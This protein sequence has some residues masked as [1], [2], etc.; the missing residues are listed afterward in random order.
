MKE[1]KL[2][3]EKLLQNCETVVIASINAEG[4]PRPVPI[5]KIATEGLSTIWMSTGSSSLKTTDFRVNPKAGL[6]F[7][8]GGD[9][10]AL[11]GEVEVVTDAESKQK[12]WQNWFIKFFPQGIKDPEYTLLKFRSKQA[13]IY[14]DDDFQRVTVE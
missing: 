13:T 12:F 3:A 9:S 6:C 7:Y 8:T 2:K 11:T 5:A 14:I 4:Y 1:I 10:V